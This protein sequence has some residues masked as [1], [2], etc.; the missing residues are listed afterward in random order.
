MIGILLGSLG[1][2]SCKCSS[3]F[4]RVLLD[5]GKVDIIQIATIRMGLS[6]IYFEGSQ[7]DFPNKSV[8]FSL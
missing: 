2:K 6:N 1:D 5:S 7:I 8:Y 3:L 4:C